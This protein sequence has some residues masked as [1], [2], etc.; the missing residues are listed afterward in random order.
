MSGTLIFDAQ[1]VL[2]CAEHAL[3]APTH[4][5][6]WG[7]KDANAALW[8][9][10][11]QGVYLMSNGSPIDNVAKDGKPVT[12]FV[13]YAEGCNPNADDFDEWYDNKRSI[14][15]GDDGAD[16]LPWCDTVVRK[17]KAGAKKVIIL[18]TESEIKME[19]K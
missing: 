1:E 14:F 10:G 15:G 5:A 12:S 9:V 3:A 19:F 2:R 18:L 11:D 16:A 17:V 4:R 6:M 7:E 8:L 13:A